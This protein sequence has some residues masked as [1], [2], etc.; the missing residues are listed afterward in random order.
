MMPVGD[1]RRGKYIDKTTVCFVPNRYAENTRTKL[2]RQVQVEKAK[3]ALKP[4]E[5]E[6][7]PERENAPRFAAIKIGLI[8]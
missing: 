8:K 3:E 4:K 1:P 5:P 6:E 7:I 2:K